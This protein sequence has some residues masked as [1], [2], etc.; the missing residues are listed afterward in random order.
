M[1]SRRD[2]DRNVTG[3]SIQVMQDGLASFLQVHLFH[4]VVNLLLGS[5]QLLYGDRLAVLCHL[6]GVFGDQ[7]KP[8]LTQ[9]YDKVG[10]G[11]FQARVTIGHSSACWDNTRIRF[12]TASTGTLLVLE[13]SRAENLKKSRSFAL[14]TIMAGEFS[15][16]A[17]NP[18]I[19]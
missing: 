14:C 11:S 9:C 10:S 12:L 17:R 7:D 8:C 13:I 16:L 19:R 6:P 5:R 1:G 2:G 15:R 3:Q 18:N 4:T